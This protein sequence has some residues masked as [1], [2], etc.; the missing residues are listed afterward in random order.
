MLLQPVTLCW[1]NRRCV[2][3]IVRVWKIY[4]IRYALS[5]LLRNRMRAT[6]TIH[7][8]LPQTVLQPRCVVALWE[9]ILLPETPNTPAVGA[10]PYDGSPHAQE[11][12][13]TTLVES[14]QFYKRCDEQ[15]LFHQSH[16]ARM[17]ATLHEQAGFSL[18]TFC[19]ILL[20]VM[21]TPK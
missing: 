15:G 16:M 5:P 9:H 21:R 7:L 4:H 20:S 11:S 3:P 13:Y 17:R 1:V 2:R 14:L 10:A 8:S 6:W 18:P 19:N 12:C